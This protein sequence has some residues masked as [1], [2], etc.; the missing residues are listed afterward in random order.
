VVS[1]SKQQ[2]I[3][4]V[5]PTSHYRCTLEPQLTA[6]E[7]KK[8]LCGTF[9]FLRSSLLKALNQGEKDQSRMHSLKT[10]SI[11]KI[12][13]HKAGSATFPCQKTNPFIGRVRRTREDRV[14][15]K[16]GKNCTLLNEKRSTGVLYRF[17]VCN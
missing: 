4:H 7:Q 5:I 3:R 12:H 8:A 9:F 16:L 10:G 13:L 2:S 15:E 17:Q 11:G 1:D 6:V 14:R